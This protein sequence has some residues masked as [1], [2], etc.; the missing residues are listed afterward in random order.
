MILTIKIKHGAN[1]SSELEKAKMVAEFALRSGSRSSKDVKHFGLKS[2]ISNQILKKYSSNKK[3]KR[4]NR[5]K[6][7]VPS[8]SIKVDRDELFIP[9]LDL[10]IPTFIINHFDNRLLA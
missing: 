7:T 6:L 8:Q 2:S 3:L 1:L 10:R 9:C 5:V 4:I